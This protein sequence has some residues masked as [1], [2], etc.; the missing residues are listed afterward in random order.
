ML[1]EGSFVNL[2]FLVT[3][4]VEDFSNQR[5]PHQL[6]VSMFDLKQEENG[7]EGMRKVSGSVSQDYLAVFQNNSK[8]RSKKFVKS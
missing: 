5:A 1:V 4:V 2:V 8:Y 6:R 3:I 7:T